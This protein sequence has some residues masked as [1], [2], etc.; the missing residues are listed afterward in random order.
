MEEDVFQRRLY[1]FIHDHLAEEARIMMGNLIPYLRH[2]H[3]D[4]VMD[5][6]LTDAKNEAKDD[7]WDPVKNG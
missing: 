4:G 2:K 3:G 5:Y 7:I 6:F 1:L